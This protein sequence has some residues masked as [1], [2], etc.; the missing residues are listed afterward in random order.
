LGGITKAKFL[1]TSLTVFFVIVLGI[2]S[3]CCLKL[4][5]Q[6]LDE[7]IDDY[8]HCNQLMSI[9]KKQETS[10]TISMYSNP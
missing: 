2:N 10:A 4:F 9:A 5:K 3:Y 8:G 7:L 1:I 6:L